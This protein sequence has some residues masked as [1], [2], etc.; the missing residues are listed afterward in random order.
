MPVHIDAAP[1]DP[2]TPFSRADARSAGISVRELLG[3]RFQRLFHDNY[4]AADVKI[5]VALR[6]R[7]ALLLCAEGSY[8]SHQTAARLFDGI[9]PQDPDVHVSVPDDG[10][11]PRRTG[12]KAHVANT[13]AEVVVHRGIRTSSARQCVLDVAGRL[14]LVDLVVLGDSLVK[15][16]HVSP[17]ELVDAADRWRGHGAKLARRAMRLVR[18]SVASPMETRLRLLIVLAGLPE[19]VVDHHLLDEAGNVRYRLDLSYP[20][21]QIAVEYE[22]RQHAESSQQWQHDITRR[23]TLDVLAWR[24]IVARAPDI[25]TDPAALLDRII[26]ALRD[27]G[28][29]DVRI[30]SQEWRRHFPGH[31][32]VAA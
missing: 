4:V 10:Y 12:V 25:Y 7:A 30:R 19:P 14:G 23:E 3:P 13:D 26:A 6:A 2:R 11:R 21:W 31:R 8:A 1:L 28:V 22:G 15:A 32:A 29:M 18:R 17:E 16:G 27:R 24:L 20:Q 5:T 9:V